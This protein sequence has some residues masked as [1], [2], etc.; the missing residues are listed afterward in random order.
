MEKC[1]DLRKNFAQYSRQNLYYSFFIFKYFQSY[2]VSANYQNDCE[3][4]CDPGNHYYSDSTN[5]FQN[6]QTKCKTSNGE[7]K[8]PQQC[9]F[10]EIE[11]TCFL[12]Y[13]SCK[14][15]QFIRAISLNLRFL[16]H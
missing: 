5:D 14:V 3:R 13:N 16:S 1:V 4:S 8:C 7:F 10:G 9:N 11:Q 2:Y 12:E 6:Y 15:S